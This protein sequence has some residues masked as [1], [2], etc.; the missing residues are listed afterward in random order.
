MSITKCWGPEQS[1]WF[2]FTQL[3]QSYMLFMKTF[4]KVRGTLTLYHYCEKM[5][6]LFCDLF[7]NIHLL[8]DF[9]LNKGKVS[10]KSSHTVHDY[11]SE[12]TVTAAYDEYQKNNDLQLK[13][14]QNY[15][16][17]G[18]VNMERNLARVRGHEQRSILPSAPVTNGDKYSYDMP[19]SK[20]LPEIKYADEG[21]GFTDATDYAS[22]LLF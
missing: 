13:T 2:T 10:F 3:P 15:Q 5:A 11:P 4:K 17:A 14:L 19:A 1:T 8:F 9:Q 7:T 12:E 16:P 21:Q 18:L 22:A 20:S 6:G